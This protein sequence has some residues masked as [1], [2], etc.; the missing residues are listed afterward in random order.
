MLGI[1][2]MPR[3]AHT[4]GIPQSNSI[5]AA[6]WKTLSAAYT[7]CNIPSFNTQKDLKQEISNFLITILDLNALIFIMAG[8]IAIWITKRIT[9][10]F[11]LIG[12]KMKAI[13]FGSVNEEIEWK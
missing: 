3:D 9:T 2:V 1:S 4:W 10:S 5:F 11:T 13:S 12:N 6:A 7:V 8:A